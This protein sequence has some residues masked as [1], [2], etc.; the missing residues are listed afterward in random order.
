[1][2]TEIVA[3]ADP[4]FVFNGRIFA[5]VV[6]TA[7]LD[8]YALSDDLRALFAFL[9]AE[10]DIAIYELS[11]RQNCELRSFHTVSELTAAFDLGADQTTHL[12]LWS[13]SVRTRPL[14]ER[15]EATRAPVPFFRYAVRGAGLI[16]L[17][18]GDVRDSVIHH[19]HFGHW[20]AA[21]AKYL[22]EE[23]VRDCDW[24]ALARLSGK[25]QRHIRGKR[26]TFKLWSR[27]VLHQAWIMVQQGHGLM[28]GSTVHRAGSPAFQKIRK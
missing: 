12:V 7:N 10:T 1:M 20:N 24:A 16:Q 9:Y 22:P 28:L 3:C 14:I 18:L 21:R 13:P 6:S 4:A 17:Y 15:V 23:L 8:F 5:K 2:Q 25:I 27:P 19:S 11:S 26:A